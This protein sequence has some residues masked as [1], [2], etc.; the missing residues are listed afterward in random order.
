MDDRRL[1]PLYA[2][3][4]DNGIP[5][6]MMTGGNA[7]PDITYTNPEPIDRVLGDFRT[8][9]WSARTATGPGAGDHPRGVP[10][11]QPVP[12]AGHLP[13]ALP[14]TSSRRP[15]RSWPTGMLFGTAYPICPLKEYTE[16][17]LTLPIK[18][19]A[20][21]RRS[22]TATPNGCWRRPAAEGAS[23][24]E[25]AA[26][27]GAPAFILTRIL[28]MSGANASAGCLATA[29]HSSSDMPL[30]N[31][32]L[33]QL[34]ESENHFGTQLTAPNIEKMASGIAGDD[35]A[36][37]DVSRTKPRSLAQAVR[38]RR[39]WRGP[40]ARACFGDDHAAAHLAQRHLQVF[41]HRHLQLVQPV[42]AF[43][44]RRPDPSKP[45]RSASANASE[46]QRCLLGK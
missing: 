19:D 16:W 5:V 35:A 43:G 8:G 6:I 27:G 28:P 11:P 14:P 36:V 4:E 2:F 26:S 22:C 21:E 12:V 24:C 41:A 46:Q 29:R 30:V 18:P 10:A 13:V 33:D 17:F 42:A 32:L 15:I 39:S 20:M 23:P 1:Y 37:L 40:A 38:A 45:T 44:A 34:P 31:C 25:R 7:G 9:P 3:C